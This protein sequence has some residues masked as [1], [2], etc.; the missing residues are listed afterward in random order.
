MSKMSISNEV[1][2]SEH[3]AIHEANSEDQMQTAIKQNRLT[4]LQNLLGN[5]SPVSPSTVNLAASRLAKNPRSEECKEVI[6]LLLGNG[7]D[8]D[9]PLDMDIPLLG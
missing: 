3:R 5:N 7:W 6:D 2:R 9:T 1:V 4:Q 8:L